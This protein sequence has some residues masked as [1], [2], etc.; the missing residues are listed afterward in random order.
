MGPLYKSKTSVGNTLKLSFEHCG[1]KLSSRD[2][3]AL[4]HFEIAG[5]DG[6][7]HPAIAKVDRN[8]VLLTSTLVKRP[9]HAR[10]AWKAFPKPF[11]NLVNSVGLPASPFSTE[12][13]VP[14]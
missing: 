9:V 13:Q 12:K 11:P 7:Y 14:E 10:Y 2:G 5:S 1:S 3:K 8:Q 6:V 4:N